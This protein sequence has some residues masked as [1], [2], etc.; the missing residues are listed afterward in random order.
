MLSLKVWSFE[1]TFFAVERK[2]KAN[3]QRR[4]RREREK[5]LILFFF[6]LFFSHSLK[7]KSGVQVAPYLV[8]VSPMGKLSAFWSCWWR[9]W[10]RIAGVVEK[11]RAERAF[12]LQRSPGFFSTC[13]SSSFK[14]LFELIK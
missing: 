13:P 9:W 4:R 12:F 10:W 2:R 8:A 1:G 14:L 3:G 5:K 6:F 11:R 7:T